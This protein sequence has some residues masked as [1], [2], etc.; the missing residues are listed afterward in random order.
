MT[1]FQPETITRT[2]LITGIQPDHRP[3]L[4]LGLLTVQTS[5]RLTKPTILE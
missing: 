1:H 3:L 4:V 5:N 2:V